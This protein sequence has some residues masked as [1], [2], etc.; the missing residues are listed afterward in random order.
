MR[1]FAITNL[2]FLLLAG[3]ANISDT[4]NTHPVLSISSKKPAKDV[5]Q[6]IRDG[7]QNV[8]VWGAGIGGTLQES[9]GSY[10]VIAPDAQ[11]PWHLVDISPSP[12]GSTIKYYFYREWQSP[13]D[14]IK[15]AVIGC[16]G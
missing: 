5:A 3:C 9:S 11:T 6:C 2:S 15:N 14:R 8:S 13:L 12:K 10:T 4:R 1:F 16:A 7:W